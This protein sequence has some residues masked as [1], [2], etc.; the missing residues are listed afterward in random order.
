MA[1]IKWT[2][3]AMTDL[4]IIDKI[5]AKRIVSK[6]SWFGENFSFLVPEKLHANLNGLYKLRIGDY[7]VIYTISKT[8][9][10][11]VQAIGHRREIYRNY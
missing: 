3:D 9:V 10:V 4:G 2:A 5:I 6:I 11:I 1:S 8:D 7:R